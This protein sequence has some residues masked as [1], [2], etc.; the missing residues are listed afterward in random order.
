MT[1]VALS[2]I[3]RRGTLW[4]LRLNSISYLSV[5]VDRLLFLLAWCWLGCELSNRWGPL[6]RSQAIEAINNFGWSTKDDSRHL[7]S[8][9]R[10]HWT[11][12]E[13][14][15]QLE[16]ETRTCWTA[17]PVTI[18]SGTEIDVNQKIVLLLP[19]DP[20]GARLCSLLL[21]AIFTIR[22]HRSIVAF[23][24]SEILSII[25]C[26]FSLFLTVHC[27]SSRLTT[28]LSVHTSLGY[29]RFEN[30]GHTLYFLIFSVF[31]LFHSHPLC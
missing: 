6:H 4:S 13:N 22:T 20:F 25:H 29:F 24:L 14:K 27:P 7:R 8:M 3:I 17:S 12:N 2:S 18:V 16:D 19:L 23:S 21:N 30:R 31:F 9:K 10:I 1:L 26:S 28:C 15:R 5:L 11:P